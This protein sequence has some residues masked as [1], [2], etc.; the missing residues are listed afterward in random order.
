MTK[1]IKVTINGPRAAG[2]TR[3]AEIIGSALRGAGVSHSFSVINADGVEGTVSVTP[4]QITPSQP[5][6]RGVRVDV[7]EDSSVKKPEAPVD[8]STAEYKFAVAH[9][10]VMGTE[11]GPLIE[12]IVRKNDPFGRRGLDTFRDMSPDHQAITTELMREVFLQLSQNAREYMESQ[13][14]ALLHSTETRRIALDAAGKLGMG[15]AQ[16]LVNA[17]KEIQDYL[18]NI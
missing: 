16:D 17:A 13:Y 14:N 15:T 6:L 10:I 5:A 7:I 18:N 1:N 12:Q 3:I 4:S 2:K 8:T 9:A 11:I